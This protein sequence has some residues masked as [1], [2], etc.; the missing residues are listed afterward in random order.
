MSGDECSVRFRHRL[1]GLTRQ[2]PS[3]PPLSLEKFLGTDPQQEPPIAATGIRDRGSPRT[4]GQRD[5]PSSSPTA[6]IGRQDKSAQIVRSRSHRTLGQRVENARGSG[7]LAWVDRP[8]GRHRIGAMHGAMVQ[9][10][11]RHDDVTAAVTTG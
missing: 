10:T 7:D 2:P 4:C 9:G 11:T 1:A 6:L 3:H 8:H 5:Q